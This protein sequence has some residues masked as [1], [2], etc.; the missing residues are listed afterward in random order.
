MSPDR[1]AILF[2]AGLAL[3]GQGVRY[4]ITRPGSAPGDVQLLSALPGHSAITHAEAATALTRPLGSGEQIDVDRADS[5]E[6]ARLP[7]VGP[8]LARTIV[9]DRDSNGPYG[10]LRALDRVP[11]IGPATLRRLAPHVRFSAAPPASGVAIPRPAGAAGGPRPQVVPVN[12]ADMVQLQ[13]LP[14]IGPARAQAIIAWRERH[15]SFFH[16]EDL[17]R[18]PGISPR[19][20]RRLEGLVTFALP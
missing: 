7:Q 11:G 1:R 15:G 12:R 19:I 6:L 4:W 18:V 9:A 2:L 3:A 16:L 5:R 13:S 20:A 14:G 8:A 17:A 10:S